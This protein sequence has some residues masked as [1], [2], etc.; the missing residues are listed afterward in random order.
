MAGNIYG[1]AETINQKL[2]IV[3]NKLKNRRQKTIRALDRLHNLYLYSDDSLSE[4]D[5]ILE[6]EKLEM[7]LDEIEQ[8]IKVSESDAGD[9]PDDDIFVQKASEFI[10]A[11]NLQDRNYIYYKRLAQS[12]EPQV[13]QTFIRSVIDK[14]VL[15]NENFIS[16]TF[17]NGIQFNFQYEKEPS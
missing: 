16:I 7:E 4:K 9:S 11:K 5:Y 14:V 17:K 12:V 8:Q 10:I 2:P 15:Q 1:K 6:R 13:I 3:L